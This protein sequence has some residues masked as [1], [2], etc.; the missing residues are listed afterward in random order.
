MYIFTQ[1]KKRIASSY[2]TSVPS[3]VS[4][5]WGEVISAQWQNLFIDYLQGLGGAIFV[6]RK[7]ASFPAAKAKA[8]SG[9]QQKRWLSV[10]KFKKWS[11]QSRQK[12]LKV[13]FTSF[14]WEQHCPSMN[15]DMESAAPVNCHVTSKSCF[16]ALFIK[17]ALEASPPMARDGVVFPVECF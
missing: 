17:G 2:P 14:N 3:G 13:N 10:G 5:H 8:S 16:Q 15:Q 11:K 12:S 9:P 1:K 7:A 4:L 6:H